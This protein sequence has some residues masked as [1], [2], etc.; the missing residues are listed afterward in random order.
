[1]PVKPMSVENGPHL[2]VFCHPNLWSDNV[3]SS[4]SISN[5]TLTNFDRSDRAFTPSIS[6]SLSLSLSLFYFPVFTV[7]KSTVSI[8]LFFPSLYYPKSFRSTIS[9][10][11]FFYH[12]LSSLLYLIFQVTISVCLFIKSTICPSVF[13]VSFLFTIQYM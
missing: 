8:F 10:A 6:L 2:F 7:L 1:M 5:W 12:F 13:F 3:P 11:V 4:S 9:L